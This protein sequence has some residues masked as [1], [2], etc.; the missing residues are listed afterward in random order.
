MSTF[1]STLAGKAAEKWLA[2]LVL[3]GLVYVACLGAAAVLGHH[4]ALNAVELQ[5]VIDRSA[6]H[7]SASS[8]GAILL[9]AAA[10]L[11]AAALAGLTARALGV[12]VERL[13]TVPDDR[14]PARLLVR[15]RRRRWLRADQERAEA[16]TRS[17]IARAITRRNAIALELPERP[18]WIGDRFHAVDERV[19]RAYDLDLTSAWPRLWLVASDSVRAELGTARDAYGA[20]ARLGG[21]ALLYLPLAVWW[22]PALPGAAV[23]AL[24][25]WIRGREAAAVLADLVEATVDLHGTLLAQELGLTGERPALTRDT[26]YDVTV[27]LRKDLPAEQPGPVP[28]PPRPSDG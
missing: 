13:W 3:P 1:L 9:T 27:I 19:Y 23:I 22:W 2:L 4:D 6:T 5:H 14:G 15:H 25:A 12:A 11:A 26:G 8:P 7:S 28:V 24:T 20:A 21:W 18:T 17:A 16:E 10:V